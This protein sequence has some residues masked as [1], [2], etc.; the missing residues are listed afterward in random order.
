MSVFMLCSFISSPVLPKSSLCGHVQISLVLDSACFHWICNA[1]FDQEF[2][3]NKNSRISR[4]FCLGLTF[5][6][7]TLSVAMLLTFRLF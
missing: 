5:L 6:D 3:V 1:P 7:T 4:W 2:M